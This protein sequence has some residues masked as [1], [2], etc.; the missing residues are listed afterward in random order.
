MSFVPDFF[1]E[2]PLL[3]DYLRPTAI[4]D[5]D[6]PA[7]RAVA[8]Q[9]ASSSAND[10]E[11]ARRLFEFVRDEIHHT[12]DLGGG[13]VT[14]RASDVLAER[15]GLCYAKSH[16]LAAML[17]AVGIPAGFCYQRFATDAPGSGFVLHGFNGVYLSSL[18]VWLRV[19]PR[20]N[21]PGVDA[22]FDLKNERLAF[23]VDAARGELTY[24]TIHVHPVAC[25]IET[26]TSGKAWGEVWA[27][28]PGDLPAPISRPE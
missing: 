5:A 10:V 18:G 2:S 23:T 20:G 26:L 16:L 9:V 25:V 28:L 14:C 4:I 11:R 27:N 8:H 3:E 21:K 1:P 24:P 6:H 7:V 12:G 15:T 13:S 17:R 19:D 22:Q